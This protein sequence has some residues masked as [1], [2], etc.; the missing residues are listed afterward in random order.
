MIDGVI[1]IVR[2]CHQGVHGVVKTRH[3]RGDRKSS[4]RDDTSCD[5]TESAL[6]A[7]DYEED[8]KHHHDQRL[9]RHRHSEEP[10]SANEALIDRKQKGVD[11]ERQC[12]RILRM[13]PEHRDVPQDYRFCDAKPGTAGIR[14]F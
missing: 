8:W 3:Q 10:T 12:Q 4:S 1:W 14:N 11:G 7:A 2:L 13:P 9:D 6:L 5:N